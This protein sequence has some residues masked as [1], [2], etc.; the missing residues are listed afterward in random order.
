MVKIHSL[1]INYILPMTVE[2]QWW[3]FPEPAG[4]VKGELSSGNAFTLDSPR[5]RDK[6]I[7]AVEASH[8]YDL[9]LRRALAAVVKTLFQSAIRPS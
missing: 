2:F 1:Y 5:A 9:L 6:I 4:A 7:R 8:P 3:E